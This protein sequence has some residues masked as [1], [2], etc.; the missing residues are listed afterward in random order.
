MIYGI[1]NYVIVIFFIC[2]EYKRYRVTS[3]TVWLLSHNI[4][5]NVSSLF[6]KYKRPYE[7]SSFC[8]THKQLKPEQ[9]KAL[10]LFVDA[11]IY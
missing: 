2:L 3:I 11:L 7:M 10:K 9:R 6:K 5:T 1:F 8:L 4:L